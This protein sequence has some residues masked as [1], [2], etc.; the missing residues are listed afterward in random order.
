MHVGACR[1]RTLIPHSSRFLL[2]VLTK[3]GHIEMLKSL[4]QRIRSKTTLKVPLLVRNSLVPNPMNSQWPFPT[5][6]ISVGHV[7]Q[8][9][10][11]REPPQ[12][13]SGMSSE[14]ANTIHG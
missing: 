13:N 8:L 3:A 10:Y 1:V 9:M 2:S 12:Q 6:S 4:E 7:C 5:S 11:T 14:Q